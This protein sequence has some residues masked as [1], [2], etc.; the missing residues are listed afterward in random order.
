MDHYSQSAIGATTCL[1]AK[2]GTLR[3]GPSS[4]NPSTPLCKVPSPQRA[5]GP[6][7]MTGWHSSH[8]GTCSEFFTE[9]WRLRSVSGSSEKLR[10]AQRVCRR[11][12]DRLTVT[13]SRGAALFCELSNNFHPFM[14]TSKVYPCVAVVLSAESFILFNVLANL[15][16]FDGDATP[17]RHAHVSFTVS[18]S[19]PA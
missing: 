11:G 13:T 14:G 15:F 10:H 4:P 5:N 9:M 1:L 18:A 2:M 19:R 7:A 8:T 16:R 3:P 17:T 12:C 6:V